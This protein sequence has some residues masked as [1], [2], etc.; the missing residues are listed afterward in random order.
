M[1]IKEL[2]PKYVTL[3]ILVA[4]CAHSQTPTPPA[5]SSSGPGGNTYLYTANT[6]FGP[7]YAD[8]AE[9]PQSAFYI[10]EPSGPSAASTY[11]VV[12]LLHAYLLQLQGNPAGDLPDNYTYWIAHL[13]RMGYTVVFPTYD[14]GLQP[15]EFT[16]NIIATWQ[17]ALTLLQSGTVPG[18]IPPTTDSLGLQTVFAGHS[19][20]AV[21][22]FAVA[23]SLTTIPNAAVPVP[24][25]IAA[26]QP[27]VG[28]T[29]EISTDYSQISS[30][31]RVVLVDGDQDANDI[32]A[33]QAIWSSLSTPIPI[34]NRD[35]LEVISDSH[36]SPA[37]IGNHWYPDTSGFLDDD[38]G[39]DNRDYNI[40]WKL[41]VGLFNCALN[42]LD[43]SFGLGHGSSDQVSMGN[44][45]DGTAVV[46]LSLPAVPT[47]PPVIASVTDGAS[48]SAAVAP[49]GL[50]TIFGSN[51]TGDAAGGATTVPLP[52]QLLDLSLTIN[53]TLVPL[54]YVSPT[55]INFQMPYETAVG[56]AQALVTTSV[57]NS[58][59][60]SFVVQTTAPALFQYDGNNAVAD[61]SDFSLNQPS[62]PASPGD[63]IV[64]FATGGG[65]VTNQLADGVPA[66]SQPLSRVT[67]TPLG[68][69]IDGEDATVSFA[70]LAPGFV[71]LL[72]MN[73]TVPSDLP[74]GAYP[75]IITIGGASSSPATINVR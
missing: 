69:K 32:P 33:A 46:P 29:G 55:Q 72:Q 1:P 14:T 54:L 25:A 13:N 51:F 11:P 3:L 61:N 12:L 26:F 10:F 40:T 36:G 24:R 60:F 42:N 44:W 66:P 41:S 27:G 19:L 70:G 74:S 4:V 34:A 68:A 47:G 73:I 31:V 49:G 5:Q 16:S 30:S 75:L 50:A 38:S 52:R 39:V 28:S 53:G 9:S 37:Q 6:S 2:I 48:F 45:S 59:V 67:A 23:Q 63:F 58:G 20:G 71:G 22:S 64:A 56:N 17:A 15:P 57:G 62:N 65:A 8:P 35:F 7:F 43:C 18:L 21:E